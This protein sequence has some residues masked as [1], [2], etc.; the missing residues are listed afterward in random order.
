MGNIWEKI[1]TIYTWC[2]DNNDIILIIIL[3]IIGFI[4]APY[5]IGIAKSVLKGILAVIKMILSVIKAPFIAIKK[6]FNS[7]NRNK[8]VQ[9]N[10]NNY[11]PTMS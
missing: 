4:L 2:C 1:K 7:F 6:V 8:G 9:F 5:I 10:N 3:G 11:I